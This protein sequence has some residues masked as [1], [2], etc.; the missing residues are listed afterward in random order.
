M[1]NAKRDPIMVDMDLVYEQLKERPEL[2]DLMMGL[3]KRSET[4]VFSGWVRRTR[5]WTEYADGTENQP[6]EWRYASA[7]RS[8]NPYVYQKG[9]AGKSNIRKTPIYSDEGQPRLVDFGLNL[10]PRYSTPEYKEYSR[11][12]DMFRD[13]YDVWSKARP[14]IS[15]SFQEQQVV[16]A[17]IVI[18]E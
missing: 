3:L 12:M 5:H 11:K 2:V 15:Y 7:F 16:P 17:R 8:C 13:V 18:D 6:S 4:V 9:R 10:T 1:E 14:I